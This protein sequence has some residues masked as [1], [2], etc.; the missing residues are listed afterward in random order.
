MLKASCTN[1]PRAVLDLFGFKYLRDPFY[2]TG[3]AAPPPPGLPSDDFIKK[4]FEEIPPPI[5]ARPPFGP[6][7]LDLSTPRQAYLITSVRK[8]DHFDA[9]IAEDEY[10][11]V[12]PEPLFKEKGADFP[13]TVFVQGTADA[14]VDA[15][16]SKWAHDVLK[17]NGV[18][19]ELYLLEGKTHGFDTGIKR[20]DPAFEPI[21]KGIDFLS[22]YVT[23]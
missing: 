23:K 21:Q 13:P 7:G 19:T 5:A 8:G 22:Q 2:H 12:D 1:P 14:V 10:D 9:I 6:K 11:R 20:D 15:K 4:V 3:S 17:K 16:F 18:A